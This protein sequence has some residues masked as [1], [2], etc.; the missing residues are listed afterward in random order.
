[1]FSG[2]LLYSVLPRVSNVPGIYRS[3]ANNP[4]SSYNVFL[5]QRTHVEIFVS[6]MLGSKK[7]LLNS[8]VM[9]LSRF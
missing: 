9:P 1:M 2:I 4:T 8:N 6:P 3:G 7:Y 5:L